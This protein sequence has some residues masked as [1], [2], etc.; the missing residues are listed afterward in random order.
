CYVG[1]E[2]VSRM[3]HRG[4]ARRRPVA[5]RGSGLAAGTPLTA[6]DMPI[7]TLGSAQGDLGLAIA[8]LDRAQ[9]ARDAGVPLMA[10]AAPVELTLPT[11]A[12]FD[13]PKDGGEDGAEAS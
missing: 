5:V 7:G 11:W 3:E 4:T 6:G 10:A 12:G 13:W 2:V 1:Q 9:R 8:R